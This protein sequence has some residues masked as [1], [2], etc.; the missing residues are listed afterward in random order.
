MTPRFFAT[1]DEL[2]SWF[3][4]NHADRKELWVGYFKKGSGM[5]S[6]DWPQS[7]DVA[8]C[9]GWIDGIRKRHDD[10]SYVIRFTPRRRNSPW[11]ARNVGRMRA[12]IEAGMVEEAGLRAFGDWERRGGPPAAPVGSQRL[13]EEFEG[14]LKAD[15]EAWSFFQ[16]TRPSYRKQAAVWVQSAKREETRLRRLRALIECSRKGEPIPPLRWTKWARRTAD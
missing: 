3:R 4:R 6:I 15:P 5:P 14:R 7:V 16:S 8:L 12:L 11:S 10:V 1:P 2:R 9:F 13:R